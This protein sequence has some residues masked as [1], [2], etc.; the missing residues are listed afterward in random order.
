MC[1]LEVNRLKYITGYVM[2]RAH[3][4]KSRAGHQAELDRRSHCDFRGNAK[5]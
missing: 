3:T 5:V 4:W 2:P 1:L